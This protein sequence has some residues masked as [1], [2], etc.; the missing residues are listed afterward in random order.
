VNLP[1]RI[2]D[3]EPSSQLNRCQFADISGQRQLAESDREPVDYSWN[4]ARISELDFE[5]E[6]TTA[7]Q[8]SPLTQLG[9]RPRL[10]VFR[11]HL[12]QAC[13][14][15]EQREEGDVETST[16]VVCR[17]DSSWNS[18][19]ARCGRTKYSVGP[20][21]VLSPYEQGGDITPAVDPSPD[22]YMLRV[23]RRS[24]LR[25]QGRKF[26]CKGARFNRLACQIG[27]SPMQTGEELLTD[28]TLLCHQVPRQRILITIRARREERHDA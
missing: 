13:C 20:P 11:K 6:E 10:P 9:S 7:E 21:N 1:E 3:Q 26:G 2:D 5:F 12:D 23:E 25:S 24:I 14:D 17:A 8:A 4:G 22:R 16:K 15:H 27:P 18:M 19:S 28:E